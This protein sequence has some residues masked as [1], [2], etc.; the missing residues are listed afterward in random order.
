MDKLLNIKL[1]VATFGTIISTLLGGWDLALY[2]LVSFVVLDYV[3]GLIAAYHEQKLDS[4]IG[5]KGITRKILLFVPVAM[6][7]MVDDLMGLDILRSFAICFYT[8]NEGLSVLE[9]LGKV[10]VLVPPS[11]LKTLQQLKEKGDSE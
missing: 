7:V 3:T 8:A 2:V 1:C 11:L 9:N 4:R 10:G 6:A 5:F